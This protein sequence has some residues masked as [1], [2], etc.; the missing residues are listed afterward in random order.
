MLFLLGVW[1]LRCECCGGCQ[2]M[3]FIRR[4]FTSSVFGATWLIAITGF[5]WAIA[6]WA[7]YSLVKR[8]IDN[9]LCFTDDVFLGTAWGSDLD[10]TLC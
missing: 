2:T 10:R 1:Q 9:F 8:F 6:Q 3:L 4:R 5:S 7:P